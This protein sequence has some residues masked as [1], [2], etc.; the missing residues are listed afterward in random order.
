MCEGLK[1]WSQFNGFKSRNSTA[2][3]ALNISML[4][5]V[6]LTLYKSMGTMRTIKTRFERVKRLA[7]RDVASSPKLLK[8]KDNMA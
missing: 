4:R 5:L 7:P 1:G 8:V 3:L 6:H 2:V